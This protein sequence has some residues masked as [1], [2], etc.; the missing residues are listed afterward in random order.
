MNLN[1]LL[2]RKTPTV[3]EIAHKHNVDISYVTNQLKKGLR[4]E[5]E[6]TTHPSVA[7]EIALDHLSEL[8]DY[9]NRLEKV[10]TNE[11]SIE[12][13]TKIIKNF[14]PFVKKELKLKSFP[15]IK[16]VNTVPGA[17]GTTFGRYEPENNTIYVVFQGRHT[18]D[19]L[20]TLAH[21]L[22]HYKQDCED[23]ITDNSGATGSDEENEANAQAGVIMRNYNQ[24]NPE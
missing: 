5:L 18:K 14:L 10:E 12:S 3:E 21:E 9:Y 22:V 13:T 17:S 16:I 20:R 24:D 23:R 19:A 6:H 11:D 15:K 8:P 7:L 2:D 4:V 1:D